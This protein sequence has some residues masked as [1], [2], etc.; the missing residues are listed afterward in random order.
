MPPLRFTSVARAAGIHV[1]FTR[2]QFQ[3]GHADFGPLF[4]QFRELLVAT[5][6][7]LAG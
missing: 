5:C 6:G 2:H 4:P 1:V 3:P 7:L